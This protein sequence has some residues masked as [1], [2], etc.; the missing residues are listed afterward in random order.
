M[1]GL[2]LSALIVSIDLLAVLGS[3]SSNLISLVVLVI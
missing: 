2:I 1:Q 3:I